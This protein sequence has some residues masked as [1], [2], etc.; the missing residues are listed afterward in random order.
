MCGVLVWSSCKV[1]VRPEMAKIAKTSSKKLGKR[2]RADKRKGKVLQRDPIGRGSSEAA[3]VRVFP[4]MLPASKPSTSP[5]Q[6][7]SNEMRA[8][9]VCLSARNKTSKRSTSRATARCVRAAASARA[10][11]SPGSKSNNSRQARRRTALLAP[12]LPW[13]T[14]PP[15]PRSCTRAERKSSP[16]R[17]LRRFENAMRCALGVKASRARVRTHT[18]THRREGVGKSVCVHDKRERSSRKR[19][20]WKQ[21]RC[22]TRRWWKS[23]TRA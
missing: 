4:F 22:R 16:R 12:T 15:P 11:H 5:R 13:S 23:R 21:A 1:H 6:V 3:C 10:S 8:V 7:L 14:R 17:W 20:R 2:P 18:H 19:K 9:S